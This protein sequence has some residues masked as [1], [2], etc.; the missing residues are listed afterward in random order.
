MHALHTREITK[1]LNQGIGKYLKD[2][3]SECTQP[4]SNKHGIFTSIVGLSYGIK[5]FLT[6][7]VP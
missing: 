7:S 1:I 2:V 5:F 3:Q 4:P 6:C